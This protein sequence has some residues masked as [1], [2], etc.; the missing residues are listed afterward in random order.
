[1]ARVWIPSLL[2]PLTGGLAE[3][4][5]PGATVGA[6]VRELE[7]RFPGIGA[8]LADGDRL[9]AGLGVAVDGTVSSLGLRQPLL[10]A[11]ELIFVSALS[12]G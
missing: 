8:R 9:R 11:S 2:R 5:V 4:D 3:V 6:V 10:P 7:T 12:G 1:M